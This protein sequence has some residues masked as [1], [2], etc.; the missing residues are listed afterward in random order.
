MNILAFGA[1]PDDIEIFCAGTLLKYKAQGHD[2]RIAMAT[3]GNIGSN[4]ASSREEIAAIREAE[5]K[6]AAQVLGA[7]VRFLRFDDQLLFDTPE[8]RRA[9]LDAIRW[10]NPDVVLTHSPDDPST[11]HAMIGK[12]VTRV[13]LGL[14]SKLIPADEAPITKKPSVFFWDTA[15]GVNFMPEAYVDITEFFEQ[16]IEALKK[17][18]SQT[19]WMGEFIEESLP[20]LC[21][22]TA[23]FR[24]MQTGC[25][26]AEGFTAFRIQ[27]FMPDFKLLP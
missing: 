3:S 26:Y 12:L 1:H 24:G 15:S 27:G 25:R 14:P 21:R 18:E 20:E 2:V 11:D 8:T 17:H 23:Q 4:T 22:V 13:I 10:A 9:V 16:K 6:A 19:G 7:E 5:Q